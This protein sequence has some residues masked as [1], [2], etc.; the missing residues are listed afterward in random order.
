[1]SSER[2]FANQLLKLNLCLWTLFLVSS[3]FAQPVI[4]QQARRVIQ[5]EA[6]SALTSDVEITHNEC[7]S[8]PRQTWD[9]YTKTNYQPV[10][11]QKDGFSSLADSLVSI[12]QSAY[13][14]GLNPELFHYSIIRSCL[15]DSVPRW[16]KKN[17]SVS[18]AALDILLTDAYISYATSLY[19]GTVHNGHDNVDWEIHISQ[20]SLTDSLNK[21]KIQANVRQTLNNFC[22][23]HPQYLKLKQ[24]L[25]KYRAM[26]TSSGWPSE[27][28][29]TVLIKKDTNVDIEDCIGQIMANM[30]RWRWIDRNMTQPYI[31]VNIAGFDLNIID[32]N[33]TVMNMKIIV[34][35]QYTQTPLFEAKMTYITLNP[36][37]EIPTSII[38]KE[39]VPSIK[40]D[41]SY[42]SK[43]NIKIYSDWSENAREIPADSIK[44]NS[45]DPSEFEYRLRQLPG[46]KNALG[47]IAFMFPNSYGVYLH[48]TPQHD[49]FNKEIR[50]FSHGCIRVERPVDLA[51][52][53][54]KGYDG[55]TEKII[56]D[57]INSNV[58]QVIVLPKAIGVYICY[59]TT[60]VD[61]TGNIHFRN[62]IYG[63]DTEL[64]D[65]LLST[66][67]CR[68]L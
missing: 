44:W 64:K 5:W 34:G 41:A 8:T 45:V 32:S 17:D 12:I 23:I 43:N 50:T 1:M 15:K 27:A 21:I 31:M 14:D 30:E 46:E 49:L 51:S 16:L 59:W 60:W 2:C 22:C 29:N 37:W 6:D 24:A 36:W 57:A 42:I 7:L 10:W 19:A 25:K 18:M 40:K 65:Y 58:H 53:L 55:W 68:R 62:D 67:N 66:S 63:N 39:I 28:E 3:V 61:N 33:K 4:Q 11:I 47:R 56:T 38:R 9:Y 13:Q 54:L 52:Y 20:L 26:E 35:K 48:D